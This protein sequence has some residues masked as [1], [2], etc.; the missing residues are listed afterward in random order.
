MVLALAMIVSL[1]VAFTGCGGGSQAKNDG[2]FTVYG[3]G[4][5]PAGREDVI[6]YYENM[7]MEKCEYPM[8]PVIG[9]ISMIMASGDYPDIIPSRVFDDATVSKYASQGILVALDE[10]IS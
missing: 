3:Y 6:N 7:W 9:D 1:A 8:E 5:A 4:G 2:K 10:Y